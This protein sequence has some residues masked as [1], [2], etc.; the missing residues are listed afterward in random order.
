[1]SIDDRPGGLD[2]RA[3]LADTVIIEQFARL[4]SFVEQ[5]SAEPKQTPG[6]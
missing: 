4:K 5:G 6:K 3:A 2:K 1:M